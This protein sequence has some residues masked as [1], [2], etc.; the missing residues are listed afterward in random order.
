MHQSTGVKIKGFTLDSNGSNAIISI[1]SN[2]GTSCQNI[3][4]EDM[5]IIR[6][7]DIVG[8]EAGTSRNLTIKDN[9]FYRLYNSPY[10]NADVYVM[11]NV[12]LL[13]GNISS[14]TYPINFGSYTPSVTMAYYNGNLISQM[15]KDLTLINQA[16]VDMN[17]N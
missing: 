3:T 14:N 11:T 10:N 6:R 8:I 4:I 5:F 1:G 12:F 16:Y 13:Q 2:A 9:V 17:S 7:K 15:C